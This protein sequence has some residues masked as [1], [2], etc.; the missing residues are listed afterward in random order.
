MDPLLKFLNN[1]AYKFDKGYPDMN[2]EQDILM[3]ENELKS[4][5]IEVNL[6]EAKKPF[7]FLSPQ[8]QK[9][10][11]EIINIFSYSKD[12]IKADSKNRII[13]LTDDSR[14]TIFSKL[15]DLG[16]ERDPNIKGSSQG[17][18]KNNEGIEIIVKPLSGQGVQ[19][20]GKQNEVDFNNIIN[21][22]IEENNGPITV[23]FIS[24]NGKNLTYKN[25]AKAQDASVS[26]ATDFDKS[27]TDLLNSEGKI[28]VGISLKKKNAIRWESS[29]TRPIGGVNIFKSFIEK[30]GKLGSE[31][32]VGK[33]DN[34]VLQ[35][36]EKQNK[37]KLYDPVNDK[38]LSKVIV[39]GIPEEVLDKVVF[40]ESENDVIVIKET[41]EGG[42][43]NYTFENGV[44]T[45]KCSLIYTDIKDVEGTEDEPVFALSNHIG[46]AYG[47][48]FRSFSKGALY[49]GDNLKGSSVEIEFN[50][51]K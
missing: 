10:A 48:E 20:A 33:F 2:N 15:E 13:I 21:S 50:D 42:F 45:I 24:S 5:G 46:Q 30:V 31:D 14:N 35:P 44:L 38:V 29:K 8:A 19:S 11:E 23:N 43:K 36:L 28:I 49:S 34:V 4:I 6:K 17:G 25:V 32:E 39:K 27:D 3:V 22:A 1:I 37:Y 12:N 41:F 40:G 51:L 7:E 16:F 18:V 26:G 47:V 9:V